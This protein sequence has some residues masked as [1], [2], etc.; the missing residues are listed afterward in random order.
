MTGDYY[1][2]IIDGVSIDLFDQVDAPVNL[3][4]VLLD[5]N[6]FDKRGGAFSNTFKVPATKK[7]NKTFNWYFDGQIED[8]SV[9]LKEKKC[10]VIVNGVQVFDGKISGKASY[11]YLSP[12]YYELNI[13]GSN[14]VWADI[15][16]DL[17]LVALNYPIVNYTPQNVKDSWSNTWEDGYTCPLVFYGRPRN[18]DYFK[19]PTDA[20]YLHTN[21]IKNGN[22]K[23][24]RTGAGVTDRLIYEFTDF[25]YWL[26]I[27]PMV[28]QMFA[29]SGYTFVSNFFQNP[30]EGDNHIVYFND[31]NVYFKNNPDVGLDEMKASDFPFEIDLGK[32]LINEDRKCIDFLK[33]YQDQFNLFFY[34]DEINKIV[35]CEPYDSFFTSSISWEAKIDYS[36]II[37]VYPHADKQNVLFSHILDDDF[38]DDMLS[39]NIEQKLPARPPYNGLTIPYSQ[40]WYYPTNEFY[41]SAYRNGAEIN[42]EFSNKFFGSYFMAHCLTKRTSEGFLDF[43]YL[44]PDLDPG[45]ANINKLDF[46][47]GYNQYCGIIMP[48]I[49][50][51]SFT[52]I[53][54]EIVSYSDNLGAKVEGFQYVRYFPEQHVF[55]GPEPRFGYYAGMKEIKK[56]FENER[57]ETGPSTF[58][59]ALWN[60]TDEYVD[61]AATI[62][63]ESY[64]DR[65]FVFNCDYLKE[66]SLTPRNYQYSNQITRI[67]FAEFE[68]GTVETINGLLHKHFLSNIVSLYS[69]KTNVTKASFK[70]SEIDI[71]QLDFRKKILHRYRQMVLLE[72]EKYN[73]LVS[74][75]TSVITY[76]PLPAT[77]EDIEKLLYSGHHC[78]DMYD[79]FFTKDTRGR[80]DYGYPLYPYN[81]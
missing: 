42:K 81:P 1:E 34:T 5:L 68:A 76:E 41:K 27:R 70:L 37:K 53:F 3:S 40:R 19:E 73:S 43:F 30:A 11:E 64:T 9:F 66:E 55:S 50:E 4:F 26:F 75:T 10:Q 80:I 15:L 67:N 59:Y 74:E 7:N 24:A 17:P 32:D 29:K 61:F 23:F 46:R 33:G 36:K 20:T 72:V 49:T 56:F 79:V 18:M 2:V 71:A 77:N 16:K 39:K 58:N 38:R 6:Y 62:T 47:D 69:D 52:E 60:R 45:P 48:V 35:Y 54:R 65:P 31:K 22:P 12:E 14:L 57:G 8:R 28:E 13:K 44:Y 21:W 51:D 78:I 25:R 63:L